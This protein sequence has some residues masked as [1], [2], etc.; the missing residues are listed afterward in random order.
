M[1]SCVSYCAGAWTGVCLCGAWMIA[2][3][4]L[5]VSHSEWDLPVG[6]ISDPSELRGCNY[7]TS[8]ALGTLQV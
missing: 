4:G 5:C 6:M 3:F 2:S 7:H 8:F 1:P